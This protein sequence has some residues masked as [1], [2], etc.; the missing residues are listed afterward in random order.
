MLSTIIGRKKEL[1]ILQETMAS[2]RAEF[3]A[4]YG[5]RRVGKTY[6][7]KQFFNQQSGI[8][9]ELTG[10]ND[11]S[12]EE[13]LTLFSE[14][15]SA[16]F[17]EDVHLALPKN[18]MN[19][20]HQ[21]TAIIE[22]TPKNKRITLF[23]DE[24][25]WL[26][27]RKS[28]F[29]KALDHYWNTHW[30]YRKKLILIVCGSAA[31]WMIEKLIYAKGGLHN[32]ITIT[33]PLQPFYLQETQEYLQYCGMDLSYQQ[34]LELYMTIGGIPHYL[35]AVKKG[36]SATQTI[37]KLCFQKG[38]TLY[39]EF[40]KLFSSLYEDSENYVRI[41][42]TIAKKPQG[43]QRQRLIADIKKISSG[44]GLN[45]KLKNLE[46]AG[47]IISFIPLGH[48]RKGIHY[49][50]IDEY[51]LFYLTWIEKARKR[52]STTPIS[53]VHW[54]TVIKTPAWYNWAGHAFEMTCFKH[55]DM[56]R[57]A[58]EIQHVSSFCGSWKYSPKAHSEKHGAQI[59]LIFDREDGCITLCEIKYTDKPFIITKEYYQELQKKKSVYQE[60]TG[61]KKQIFWAIIASSGIT[62]NRYSKMLFCQVVTLNDLFQNPKH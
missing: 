50:I 59:D 34:A 14:S 60:C 33:L 15:L 35:N 9:F 21:L 6:L 24:L 41:I 7:I 55:I 58:L 10:L 62:K 56:V 42:R 8:F 44:G 51:V 31:S 48:S 23:F 3:I 37:N 45:E 22:K 28:G 1:K 18:W 25:P 38:G 52:S 11:G 13:Q 2:Q 16:A 57:V 27:T 39:D 36:L 12:F 30:T 19:A 5:R 40:D 32:R 47:F 54:E 53:N 17:Y 61:T 49:R 26:A 43:L 29:L 4:V 20:L 46:E